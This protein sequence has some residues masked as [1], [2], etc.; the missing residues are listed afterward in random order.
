MR[1]P[2][3]R[4][5]PV[6]P[7]AAAF[8]RCQ[9]INDFIVMSEGNSNV[10]LIET[11]AGNILVNSGM[12]FEAPVH[13]HN[14]AQFSEAPIR[15]LVLTQGHVDHVGGVQYFRERN[16]GLRCIAQ[17]GNAE[18]Q[19]YDAR[20]QAFRAARSAFRFQQAFVET[21]RQY[22]EAG[23]TDLNAQDSPTPDITFSERHTLSLGGLEIE[24]IAAPGAETNDSL[25]IWLPQQ[26]IVLT[27]N[28]FGCPF[29][30]F[31]NL[32]TIR[33]DRYRDAL[34]CA[35]AAQTVLDLN[36]D[37]LLY[38]HHAPVEGAEVIR[39]EITAYRDAIHHVHDAVVAG[40]NA[41]IPLHQLQQDITLPQECEVGQGY[42]KLN[43]SI[44]AIWEHYAG[45]F[46]HE[47]T[48][49]LYSVPATAIYADLLQLAGADALV[50]RAGEKASRGEYEEA[51]HL[52]DI[53]LGA[54]AGHPAATELAIVV[55]EHLLRDARAFCHTGNFWLEGWLEHQI[56]LLRGGNNSPL[57]Y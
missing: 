57:S 27:G 46:K 40:M 14:L 6:G 24:L 45:W 35:A 55:H 25:V 9:R 47:S 29:G 31:P 7:E 28:L 26:R 19:A 30:H 50:T 3:Y 51:L 37:L 13:A 34:T 16:P 42:G 33:G 36:A 39:S 38:G 12:G 18:H 23:Y 10:Y 44:R 20:L 22:A 49:E 21:F 11:P 1:E 15:H 5:R 32:V 54:D 8:G 17:A 41:G 56:R 53:V 52:L 43:W 48:T 4:Q 2:L